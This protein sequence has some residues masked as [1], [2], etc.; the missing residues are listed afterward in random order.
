MIFVFVHKLNSLRRVVFCESKTFLIETKYFFQI[1]KRRRNSRNRDTI[2]TKKSRLSIAQSAIKRAFKFRRIFIVVDA[3]CQNNYESLT[4]EKINANSNTYR[5]TRRVRIFTS[6]VDFAIIFSAY[7][8]V[9]RT[10]DTQKFSIA[11]R[12]CKTSRNRIFV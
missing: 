9:L 11:M 7:R 8:V 12:H 6:F 5:S 10:D 1:A 4:K 2:S 3:N